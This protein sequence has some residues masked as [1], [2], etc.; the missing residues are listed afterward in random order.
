M[1]FTSLIGYEIGLTELRGIM[2][3]SYCPSIFL[4]I[5]LGPI[6]HFVLSVSIEYDFLL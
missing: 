6:S 2:M 3:G 1:K 4:S 5:V